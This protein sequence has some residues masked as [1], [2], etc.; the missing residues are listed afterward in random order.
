MKTYCFTL[1]FRTCPASRTQ[2]GRLVGLSM[3]TSHS[4]PARAF[5]SPV[6]RSPTSSSTGAG[7]SFGRRPRLKRVSLCPRARA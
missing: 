6:L 2:N 5:R 3:Q 4:R 7:H 1:P